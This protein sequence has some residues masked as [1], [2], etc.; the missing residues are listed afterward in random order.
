MINLTR[1]SNLNLIRYN[2]ISDEGEAKLGESLS[3]LTNLT[4]LDLNF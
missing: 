3:K 4:A 1:H 2:Q